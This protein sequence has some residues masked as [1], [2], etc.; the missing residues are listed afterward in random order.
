MT[1]KTSTLFKE[2][3]RN[4]TGIDPLFVRPAS[5][6]LP[7]LP[8]DANNHI[9]VDDEGVV[10]PGDGTIWISDEYG[11][12]VYHYSS[13]GKLLNVIRPPEAVVP[14]RMNGG[15]PVDQFS[16]N[17]PPNGGPTYNVG[18]PVS[19]RQNNQGAEGLTI[20]PDHKSSCRC[21]TPPR[22]RPR[23]SFTPSMTTSSW[24]WRVTAARAMA[25]PMPSRSIAAPT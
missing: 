22:P 18:N 25:W 2:P 13:S 11:P 24:S 6:A 7:A 10:Y 4:T 5:G 23:A 14:K 20:S 15:V 9:A 3:K 19:G 1:Y 12:Y 17:A 16:A 21:S 8:V